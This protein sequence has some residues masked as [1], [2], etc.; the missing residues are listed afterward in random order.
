[1]KVVKNNILNNLY[2]NNKLFI[3]HCS[4]PGASEVHQTHKFNDFLDLT[5]FF[6]ILLDS[7]L[8]EMNDVKNGI[9]NNSE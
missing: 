2:T 4:P 6:Q 3:L 7:V 9:Y 1:M 5:Q 8:I